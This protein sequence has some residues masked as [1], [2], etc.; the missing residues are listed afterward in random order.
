MT[1]DKLQYYENVRETQL[2]GT[3]LENEMVRSLGG[4]VPPDRSGSLEK[5]QN[6]IKRLEKD[7]FDIKRESQTC[8][9]PPEGKNEDLLAR[10][11]PPEKCHESKSKL[12]TISPGNMSR[13]LLGET[14]PT[15]TAPPEG[16]KKMN[17]LVRTIPQ[18][19]FHELKMSTVPPENKSKKLLVE[20]VPHKKGPLACTARPGGVKDMNMKKKITSSSLLVS[21]VPEDRL[22]LTTTTRKKKKIAWKIKEKGS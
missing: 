21:T 10:T 20:T 14:V 4:E 13:K 22:R 19:N 8:T 16:N 15:C 11:V 12:S 1:Q 6:E 3:G 18:G 9:A 17:L 2:V 5:I 7:L